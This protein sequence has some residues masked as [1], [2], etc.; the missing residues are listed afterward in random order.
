MLNI[1]YLI[2]DGFQNVEKWWHWIDNGRTQGLWPS[3]TVVGLW[4]TKQVCV[5]I[6]YFTI[7]YYLG[8][9]T[10][11]LPRLRS[12]KVLLMGMQGL[13]AEIAKNL[14]LSGVHSITLKDH[15]SVSI[16]DR[17]SQFLIP[18]D[19]EERNVSIAYIYYLLPRLKYNKVVK[20]ILI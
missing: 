3:N 20:I 15:T 7:L 13:G 11:T 19:S 17:C 10:F 2:R 16:L 8:I 14:I 4:R 6:S 5:G 12:L 1:S 18:R 9:L